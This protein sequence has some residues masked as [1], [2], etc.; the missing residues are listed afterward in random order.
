MTTALS[1]RGTPVTVAPGV[2]EHFQDGSKASRD[3][4]LRLRR[5]IENQNLEPLVRN[6]QVL[7]QNAY[8]RKQSVSSCA[9]PRPH[10]MRRILPPLG[11]LDC[12]LT[13]VSQK[14]LRR[15]A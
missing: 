3:Y 9:Q 6:G 11:R 7:L 8:R 1:C 13:A 12:G 15:A 5:Q 2:P 10:Q 14:Q 4:E